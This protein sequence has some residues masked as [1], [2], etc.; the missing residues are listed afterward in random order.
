[1]STVLYIG[2]ALIIIL[3]AVHVWMQV[4][5]LAIRK[6]AKDRY[7]NLVDRVGLSSFPNLDDCE[8]C[9]TR[10]CPLYEVIQEKRNGK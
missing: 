3:V 9:E 7:R 4:T 5:K 6:R 8:E 1:M 2:V 10:W